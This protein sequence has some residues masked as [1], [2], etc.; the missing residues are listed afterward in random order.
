MRLLPPLCGLQNNLTLEGYSWFSLFFF[1]LRHSFLVLLTHS[2][3]WPLL[4]SLRCMIGWS[5]FEFALGVL[6]IPRDPTA[7]PLRFALI[8]H[9]DYPNPFFPILGVVVY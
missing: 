5:S 1:F 6:P 4:G 2:I 9:R 7:S 3:R 8:G